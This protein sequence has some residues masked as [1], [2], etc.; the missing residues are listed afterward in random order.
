M[1]GTVTLFPWDAVM[2][3]GMCSV[4][5]GLAPITVRTVRVAFSPVM[6]DVV[7]VEDAECVCCGWRE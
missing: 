5:A 2:S 6:P 3:V 1:I 4:L 7:V